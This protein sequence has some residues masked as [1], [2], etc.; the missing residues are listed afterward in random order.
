MSESVEQRAYH[1][2]I[3]PKDLARSL[4]LRFDASETRAHWMAGEAGRAVVQIQSRQ[5]EQRDPTTAVTVHI[6]P[7]KTGITVSVSEQKVLSV[8]ADMAKTGVEAW[9]NPLRLLGELDDIARNVRWLGLRS[10][11]WKAVDDYCR[12]QG[13]GRGAAGMLLHIICPYCSTP[14]DIGAQNCKSCL[15][16]LAAAQP[17]VCGRC[18]FL[19]A[20]EASLCVNCGAGL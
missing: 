3:E 10:E 12:T 13:S 17:I 2:S 11:V 15:A 4:V 16:P 8:A 7:T 19:N 1:G 20:P 5:M 18:G 9:L 6:S 14:N